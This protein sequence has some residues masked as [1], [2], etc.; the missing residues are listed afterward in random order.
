TLAGIAAA[1]TV[2]GASWT[3][4]SLAAPALDRASKWQPN[5][6][7]RLAVEW[8]YVAGRIADP[9]DFG[10]IVALS[11]TKIPLGSRTQELLVERQNFSGDK[12]FA[13]HAYIGTL[14]YDQ[15]SATYTFQDAQSPVSATWQWDAG[16]SA[17]RL[18]VVSPELTLQ[19]V[20]L[21]PQGDL[22]PEGGDGTITIAPI[23]GLPI[24]S[25]YYADWAVV[26]VGGTARGVARV[27]IQGLYLDSAARNSRA[28]A[29]ESST[30]YDHHWFAVAGQRDGAPIWISAWR[31]EAQDGPRW[32]V[33]IAQGTTQGAVST[34]QVAW[35]T[36]QSGAAFP[37][38]V[39]P[40]AWQPLPST[41]AAAASG[42][43]TGSAWH[44]SAGL[45]APGDL[46]DLEIVVPPGQ[47]APSARLGLIQGLDWMEE[48]VGTFAAGTV[49]GKPLA[50]VTLAVAETT[51]EFLLQ[52]LPLVQR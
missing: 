11:D 39:L 16:A 19:N 40:V 50:G 47:F 48:G 46:I 14:D 35:T 10:F 37:L 42:Q 20:V 3:S 25:D 1:G 8:R 38:S 18:S 9:N 5:P 17:Y 44:L 51:A 43:R 36:E 26:E 21:R 22:I 24:G 49:Q 28:L 29:A 2:T 41:A 34:W 7:P 52:H 30:D 12:A 13:T 23:L 45:I 32:D 4:A 15:G 27:D 33:T 31:M 6:N